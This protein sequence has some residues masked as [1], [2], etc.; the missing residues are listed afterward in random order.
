MTYKT[1]KCHGA[2][3]LKPGLQAAAAAGEPSA[4]APTVWASCLSPC[5][6]GHAAGENARMAAMCCAC[7]SILMS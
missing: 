4:I 7:M 1:A 3:R 5:L 2:D 6:V